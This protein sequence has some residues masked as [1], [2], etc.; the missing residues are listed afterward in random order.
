[1]EQMKEKQKREEAAYMKAIS[2]GIKA[3]IGDG[4]FLLKLFFGTRHNVLDHTPPA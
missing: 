1:M 4:H 2:R 3:N